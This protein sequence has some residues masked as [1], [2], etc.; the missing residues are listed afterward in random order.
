M[1]RVGLVG[2]GPLGLAGGDAATPAGRWTCR[3]ARPSRGWR[4]RPRSCSRSVRRRCGRPRR[5]GRPGTRP[6]RA[7]WWSGS[8]SPSVGG[9]GCGGGFACGRRVGD[10]VVSGCWSA[11][12]RRRGARAARRG[13][14]RSGQRGRPTAVAAVVATTAA[15]TAD[16]AVTRIP[17]RPA[18]DSRLPV[19]SATPR[20]HPARAPAARTTCHDRRT[21]PPRTPRRRN[22]SR[23]GHAGRP[24]DPPTRAVVHS[25]DGSLAPPARRGDRWYRGQPAPGG[26]ADH[27]LCQLGAPGRSGHR[28]G[29]AARAA[30]RRHRADPAG[31]GPARGAA[32][33][34]GP[35]RRRHDRRGVLD[36]G[37]AA[38]RRR[39]C[40]VDDHVEVEGAL[41]RRFFRA[42]GAVASRYEVEA[43]RVTRRRG[44]AG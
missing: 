8:P 5:S 35:G 37:G 17:G 29:G 39:R 44:D 4:R 1:G 19:S 6:D 27:G 2:G 30:E 25:G 16:P 36:G 20:R 31:R 21:A 22:T 38:G 3:T 7:T 42:G 23:S 18:H 28:D 24:Q 14:G 41:R 12:G 11:V 13:G 26:G 40:E 34:R 9:G 43:R 32:P 10:G 15:R 33:Q